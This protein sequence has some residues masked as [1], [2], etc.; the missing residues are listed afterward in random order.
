MSDLALHQADE[1]T[2]EYVETLLT[3][4]DL[5]ARDVRSKPDCFYVA[6]VDGERVGVGGLE[7]EGAS[8]LLRSVVVDEHAR[9]DGL[10]T[11]LCEALE[12][13]ARKQDVETLYLLTTT[14]AEFFAARGYERTDRTDAPEAI[15]NTT[16]FA[17]LC[18]STAT[19]MKKSL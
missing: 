13:R 4:N 10:G 2:V 11:A 14:A 18:P 3:A 12:T 5:P 19:C 1:S 8:G 15:R 7:I 16:E 6:S 17:D 9:G